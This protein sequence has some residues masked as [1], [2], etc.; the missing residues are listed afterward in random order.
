MIN[1]ITEVGLISEGS[2]SYGSAADLTASRFYNTGR[3]W[4]GEQRKET[5]LERCIASAGVWGA[6]FIAKRTT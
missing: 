1:T 2:R 4:C 5:R 6:Y 3:N